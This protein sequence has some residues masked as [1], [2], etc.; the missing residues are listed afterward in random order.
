MKAT[1]YEVPIQHFCYLCGV[2]GNLMAECVREVSGD[3]VYICNGCATQIYQIIKPGIDNIFRGKTLADSAEIK[4]FTDVFNRLSEYN[5]YD[6]EEKNLINELIKTG[7]FTE[8]TSKEM[9]R[10]AMQ[11]G[12][13]YE[14]RAGV[15]AKA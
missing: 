5:S 2:P 6:V 1:R 12:Q 3:I 14:R 10:K 4:T 8:E 13:I 15:Y 7:E 11:I 9:I